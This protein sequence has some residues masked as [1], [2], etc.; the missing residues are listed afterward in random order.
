MA[1]KQDRVTLLILERQSI[2]ETLEQT[3]NPPQQVEIPAAPTIQVP[4]PLTP[5]EIEELKMEPMPDPAEEIEYLL[6][7]STTPPSRVTSTD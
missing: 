7:L 1:Q 5:E 2:L 4:P 6:G 3:M